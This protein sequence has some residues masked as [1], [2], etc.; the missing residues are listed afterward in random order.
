MSLG[1]WWRQRRARLLQLWAVGLVAACAVTGASAMGYLESLQARALD[2]L[3]YLQ[4][5][6]QP[7]ALVIVAIDDAAFDA[8]GRRQ[9]LPRDYLARVL[10]GVTRA[11]AAAVGFDISLPTAGAPEA[12]RALAR[13][14]VEFG[15]RGERRLVVAGTSLPERGPLADPAVARVVVQSAP[16]VPVDADAVVRRASLQVGRAPA[17]AA[18]V[19]NVPLPDPAA[20]YRIN[21]IG[22]EGSFLA[23]PS[24]AVAAIGDAG[25][26]VAGDNPLSGRIVLVGGTFADGRDL[27]RTPYGLMPGVEIQANIVHMLVTGSLVR[28]AGWLAGFAV[29]LIAVLLA[30][31]VMVAARP[32][33]GTV[34]CLAG[35]LLLGVPASYVAFSRG[36][37]WVD[38][39][40]PVAVTSLLGVGADVL[41][42]RRLRDAL[43]R[44][45]SPEIAARVER[46]P[47]EL[48]GE[49]RQVS[50]LFSDL[51]GF[52]TLSER[53]APTLMAA[54]LTEYFDA[55]TA[56]IFARRGMV[57]DF[58]GDAI[59]AVFGA[60][61]DDPEHARHAIESAL[62]MGETLAVLNGRWQAEGLPPLRMGL[63]IHTGEVFAGN[64]GRAGKV[65]YAVVGDTVNLASRVEGLNKELG[66]TMLVT[67]AA[68][69]AAGLDLEVNDRGPISVKGREEPVRV[70]EVI[71]LRP[72][73]GP[74]GAKP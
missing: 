59:L 22:P 42:R 73:E 68:Y 14:I 17:F 34:V 12:D 64:V 53:M 30:G 70:Y 67:E 19:A 43:G 56:T 31:L 50:I 3:I 18:A 36:G 61:L 40:L 65:K 69:R 5:P 47:A 71:G 10:R 4:S 8:L 60:P 1:R 58:I 28:P 16:D 26:D 27:H 57:N 51:R 11:G 32:L 54:R 63:G 20:V 55:M 9:P 37:Y 7:S 2:L 33:W 62:A 25:V 72:A 45:V 29:Q 23:I 52:T 15:G 74:G 66:T 39:L 49:R 44:Y 41:A 46:N 24:D 48:A 35:A 21:F 38:F 13:A 6:R